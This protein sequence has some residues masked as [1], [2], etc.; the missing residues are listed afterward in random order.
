MPILLILSDFT[1]L[2]LRVAFATVIF[3]F[4]LHK[5]RK[6]KFIGVLDIIAGLLLA[7]GFISR[8]AALLIAL[9]MLTLILRKFLLGKRSKEDL[10]LDFI[11]FALSLYFFTK[12]GGIF[13][14]DESWLFLF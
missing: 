2:F 4:G 10:A 3:W 8:W 11:L 14:V 12:G 5:F 7:F 13:S 6:T 1:F 9:E